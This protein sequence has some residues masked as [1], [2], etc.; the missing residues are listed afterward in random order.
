MTSM[1]QM[2]SEVQRGTV[3]GITPDS[4]PAPATH[5]APTAQGVPATQS[6]SQQ[7]KVT[8]AIRRATPAAAGG[9]VIP[10]RSGVSL[11]TPQPAP[12]PMGQP[13]GQQSPHRSSLLA[14]RQS[15][16]P[17][18]SLMASLGGSSAAEGTPPPS[19]PA[20]RSS[21]GSVGGQAEGQAEV[22]IE[23][24]S[25]A[26]LMAE[27]KRA[28]EHNARRQAMRDS[29]RGAAASPRLPLGG[30]HGGGMGGASASHPS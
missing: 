6:A 15:P 12:Q 23:G 5:G 26:Q 11:L 7:Q 22:G 16:L 30:E 20:R 27:H 29:P 25:M 8:P 19:R 1:N 10:G 4:L 28:R 2:L 24:M 21:R 18:G 13:M 3:V 14:S 17:A 9:G